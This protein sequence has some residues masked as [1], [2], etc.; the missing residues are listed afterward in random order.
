VGFV[1]YDELTAEGMACRVLAPT[2]IKKSVED[3]KK[4]TDDKDAL[5]IH[6]A[7]KNHVVARSKLPAIWIP[8]EQTR[9]AREVVRC[10]ADWGKKITAVKCEIQSLLKRNGLEKVEGLKGNWTVKHRSWVQSHTE[11]G[12]P[13][14]VGARQALQSL[15]RQ[16][17]FLEG[18]SVILEKAVEKKAQLPR[19]RQGVERLESMR[20][21]RLLTAMIFLT[22]LG[23]MERFRNRR[24]VGGILGLVP[25][26][27]ES[28]EITDRKGHITRYGS[29]R[30]RRVLCQAVWGR[31]KQGGPD[32]AF[33]D[34]L[35]ERNPKKKMI[36][37]VA[38][39]RKLGVKMWHEALA[40]QRASA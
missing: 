8:D 10:R 27:D 3:Q 1:L 6:E 18:E 33:Y 26:S 39:M 4:K 30:L 2:K 35:V 37:V 17:A 12:S 7:L 13:L 25:S 21:V 9:D 36:A 16:L 23:D 32:R 14:G 20:G 24:Q 38:C 29:A 15:L 34:R 11:K 22:E 5:R 19:Y 31:V 28:G 40:A